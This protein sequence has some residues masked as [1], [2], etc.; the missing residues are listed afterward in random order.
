MAAGPFFGAVMVRL[1]A[2]VAVEGVQDGGGGHADV[3]GHA[4]N[5]PGG[6]GRAIG[7]DPGAAEEEHEEEARGCGGGALCVVLLLRRDEKG[8][9]IGFVLG[10]F[11]VEVGDE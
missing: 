11:H 4:R 3:F 2:R 7:Y 8:M 5:G 10:G 6:R 1:D 9:M